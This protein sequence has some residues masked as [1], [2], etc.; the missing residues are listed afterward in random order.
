MYRCINVTISTDTAD[1]IN[2]LKSVLKLRNKADVIEY[3]INET[4]K[5]EVEKN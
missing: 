2:K 5:R 4:Y 3:A 1:R